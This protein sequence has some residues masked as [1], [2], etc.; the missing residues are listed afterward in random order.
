[1]F[2]PEIS[3]SKELDLSD[4][5]KTYREKF[6]IP[7]N[8]K[9]EDVI[10]LAGNSLG[11]QPK[12]VRESVEQELYDWEKIALEGHTNAKNPWLPYHEF[13]TDQTARLVGAKPE[14]VINMNALTVNL[15]LLFVSFYR[16]TKERHKILIET[17]AFPSD[18]YA[19]QSQI[20]FHGFDVESSLIEMKPREGEDI[21]RT[22]DIEELIE[23]EGNSI[24]L[25]WFAGVNY[26]TGQ[27]FEQEKIT[28]A[29]HMKGCVVG[30][31]LAHAAG[32]LLMNLHEWEVDFAVWCNY[33]YMNAG[34]GAVGGS[35][36]N[37]RHLKDQS[38]PKFLGWWGHD[39]ETRFLME[40]KYIA[41]PTAESWQLSNPPI[42]QLAALR[43]SLDIFDSAGMKALRNKSEQL[44]SYLEFLINENKNDLVEIITPKNINERGCQLSLRI[45]SNGRDLY[46]RLL[47]EG[48]VCD[49][50]EPDVIRVA[51]APLYNKFEDVYEFSKIIFI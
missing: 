33:K 2:S 49:W 10:Y 3:F 38:L 15:H 50:R 42:L 17:K 22:E 18:H 31:D 26:Y 8:K 23:R 24:A 39:K 7:K 47:K 27:A 36:V 43:A 16:P 32:N 28:K 37:E 20:K 35:Y 14:E 44:T 45:K 46:T 12:T 48:I 13:L 25:I 19:I 4:P 51:P 6:H 1:M 34:P 41:I 11:L 40:H 30:F 21:I 29:G 9:G 5:L